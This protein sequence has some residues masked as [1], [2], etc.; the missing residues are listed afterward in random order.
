M[1]LMAS[2]P[3]IALIHPE[4]PMSD[5]QITTMNRRAFLMAST[6]AALSPAALLAFDA[7]T[8]SATAPFAAAK[9]AA[10]YR[11]NIGDMEATVVSD[12]ALNLGPAAGL[13]PGTPKDIVDGFMKA[14]FQAPETVIGQENCLVVNTGDKLV[15]IDSGMG[16]YKAFGP[17]AGRLG[18]NLAAAG[19]KP[20]DIDAIILTHGHI[21]H[22][23]GII[24][25]D[26]K[27]MFPNAQLMMSKTE[28]DFWTDEAKTSMTGMMKLLV[29]S[30][31]KNLLPNKDRLAFVENGKE[32][33][34]GIQAISTP[35]HT[36]GHTS[37]VLASAGKTFLY[38]GDVVNHTAISIKNPSWE[39]AFDAD[40]KTA[41]ATRMRVLDMAAKDNLTLIGY[42][43][44][45]PGIGNVAREGASYRFIPSAMDL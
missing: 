27:R 41:A 22:L 38:T 19:I 14:E 5:I 31:R 20:E 2:M 24:G 17:A 3:R 45:F 42:H 35:G 43:F 29:D 28:Y 37:Y 40:P 18:S 23:S 32:V 9:S 21:D 6:A 34:K 4:I 44:A 16:T 26:G 39:L 25:D 12:G 10:W 8:A 13:Y 36:P 7:Q 30:A 33:I 11:F 15:L 1:D